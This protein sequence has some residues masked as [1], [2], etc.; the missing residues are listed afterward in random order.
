MQIQSYFHLNWSG[1]KADE[2]ELFSWNPK[3]LSTLVPWEFCYQETDE[4]TQHFIGFA[5]YTE[6]SESA[7]LLPALNGSIIQ[8]VEST[9]SV[10]PSPYTG[11][12]RTS[13][14]G[15][16]YFSKSA[17]TGMVEPLDPRTS[18]LICTAMLRCFDLDR[19]VVQVLV[20]KMYEEI[21]YTLSPERTVFVYGC[22]DSSQWAYLEDAHAKEEES[23]HAEV[24]MSEDTKDAL[25]WVEKESSME[26]MGYLNTL[27][28]VRKFQT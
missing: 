27:R 7:S 26:R 28:R 12:P 10:I 22:C 14:Y 9:S 18:K 5:F 6:P 3:P 16:P 2:Q 24:N 17:R 23:A 11:L 20:P 15:I 4:N 8:I 25:P 13:R 21:L 1:K 19:S